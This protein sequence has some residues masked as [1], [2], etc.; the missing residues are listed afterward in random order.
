MG[1]LLNLWGYRTPAA[2]WA[3]ILALVVSMYAALTIRLVRNDILKRVRLPQLLDQITQRATALANLMRQYPANRNQIRVEM[4][5][6]EAHLKVLRRK[7]NGEIS[8][9]VRGLQA[10][11]KSYNSTP[12]WFRPT[13]RNNKDNAWNIYAQMNGLIE[14]LKHFIEDQRVVG[15]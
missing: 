2:E 4:S 6:C 13:P 14:E 5:R 1:Q 12:R 10:A 11:I 3:G 7:V 15:G 8:M 9:T